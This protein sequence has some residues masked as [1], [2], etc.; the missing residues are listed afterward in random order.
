MNETV[1]ASLGAKREGKTG[2]I[3]GSPTL[4]NE[5]GIRTRTRRRG[6]TWTRTERVNNHFAIASENENAQ[7]LSGA[8]PLI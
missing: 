7:T 1:S 8:C 3:L 4:N 5:R 6:R 2:R